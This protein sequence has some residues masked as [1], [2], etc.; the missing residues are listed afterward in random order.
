MVRPTGLSAP[1]SIEV[2]KAFSVMMRCEA[3]AQSADA[4]PIVVSLDGLELEPAAGESKVALQEGAA[5]YGPLTFTLPS[6]YHIAPGAHE[7]T[8]TLAGAVATDPAAWRAEVQVAARAVQV[9]V[10]PWR[11]SEGTVWRGDA[12]YL[13][14]RGRGLLV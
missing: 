1:E 14:P 7:L 3:E 4:L 2:G 11:F 8:A 12:E 5:E 9:A 6:Y 13:C 10:G